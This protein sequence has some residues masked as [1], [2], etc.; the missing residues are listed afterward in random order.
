VVAFHQIKLPKNSYILGYMT[1]MFNQD[2]K[3]D[4]TKLICD[5]NAP[6]SLVINCIPHHANLVMQTLLGLSLVICL[7]GLLQT[8]Q[9]F[10]TFN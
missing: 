6:N 10:F 3:I 9:V 4:V 5:N 8:L 1:L 7:Q 2:I